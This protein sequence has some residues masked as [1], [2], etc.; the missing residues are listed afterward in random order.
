MRRLQHELRI[1]LHFLR[2]V[3][4]R[5]D[6]QIEFLL[7]LRLGRLN[8]HGAVDDQRKAD[9]IRME[10]IIDEAFGDVACMHALAR[11]LVVAEDAFVHVGLV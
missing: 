3:D 9:G 1:F 8:H 4:E 2:D 5:V 10:S 6:K 11:L 7:A